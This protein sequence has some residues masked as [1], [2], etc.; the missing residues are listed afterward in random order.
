MSVS[1]FCTYSGPRHVVLVCAL[2]AD[3]AARL[4]MSESQVRLEGMSEPTG[5]PYLSE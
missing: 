4:H 1:D 5:M 3:L 2:A